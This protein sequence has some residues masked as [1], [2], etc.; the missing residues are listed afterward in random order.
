MFSRLKGKENKD[1][2]QNEMITDLNDEMGLSKTE[3]NNYEKVNRV[4]TIN[5]LGRF[6]YVFAFI[7]AV[8]VIFIAFAAS[9]ENYL[10]IKQEKQ[11]TNQLHIVQYMLLGL[12]AA[13]L[14]F[15]AVNACL[16]RQWPTNIIM[17]WLISIFNGILFGMTI[18]IPMGI[19]IIQK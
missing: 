15:S 14:V 9:S 18:A 7:V 13:L 2:E 17:L 11:V 3:L 5:V 12:D 4:N 10:L 8:G 6:R 1:G 16:W 19:A